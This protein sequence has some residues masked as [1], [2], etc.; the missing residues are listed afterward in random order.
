MRINFV[1]EDGDFIAIS[2]D[3]EYQGYMWEEMI[4]AEV[5]KKD[6]WEVRWESDYK[7]IHKFETKVE[8]FKFI[9]KNY[10]KFNPKQNGNR[11]K[12]N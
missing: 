2:Q 4:W 11:Y 10:F 12:I 3:Q 6:S 1:K 9:E 8:A 5:C 7:N